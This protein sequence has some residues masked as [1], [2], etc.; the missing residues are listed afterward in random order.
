[1]LAACGQTA[2]SRPSPTPSVTTSPRAAGFQALYGSPVQLYDSTTGATRSMFGG[3]G[4]YRQPRFAAA[5]RVSAI[6]SDGIVSVDLN[7]GSR[8]VEA[9]GSF[10][11]YAWGHGGTLAAVQPANVVQGSSVVI[12]VPGKQP[13]TFSLP[14]DPAAVEGDTI[15]LQ[16]SPDG[17]LLLVQ[18]SFP[19]S[20][21]A[22]PAASSVQVRGLDGTLLFAAPVVA[23]QSIP[24]AAIWGPDRKVYYKD[25]RG[26]VA[27]DPVSGHSAVVLAGMAWSRPDLSPDGRTIV[28]EGSNAG[29]PILHLFDVSTGKV[30]GFDR[31]TTAVSHPQFV[32]STEL[33]FNEEAVCNQCMTETTTLSPILGYDLTTRTEAPTG[34]AGILDDYDFAVRQVLQT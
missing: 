19:T 2:T 12:R 27:F 30:G 15:G 4:T 17:T 13:V 26:V 28:F 25:D 34:L 21:A 20:V 6:G 31:T 10:A 22:S 29:T 8:R 7:G 5:D 11:S 3:Q 14:P 16:F 24:H 1:M 33:W 32:A 9:A 18:G 23:T